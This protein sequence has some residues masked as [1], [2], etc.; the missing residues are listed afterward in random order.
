MDIG[1][2][3]VA[4]TRSFRLIKI[5]WAVYTTLT[6]SQTGNETIQMKA[7]NKPGMRER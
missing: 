6:T 2:N 4:D 3:A 7:H 1:D 5:M